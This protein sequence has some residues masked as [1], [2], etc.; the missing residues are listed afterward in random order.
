MSALGDIRTDLARA[1]EDVDGLSSYDT[2]PGQVNTPA[3]VVAP[4]DIEYHVDFEGGATYTLTIQFLVS[5]GD[6]ATAQETLDGFVSHDGTA[7][8]AIE[9]SEDVNASVIG[10]QAYGLTQFANTDYLGAQLI[11]RVLVD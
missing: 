8:A 6:W 5:I 11:V 9:A 3:A 1:L 10:I 2:V 4:E 7:V